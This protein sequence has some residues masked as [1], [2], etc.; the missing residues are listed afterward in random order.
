MVGFVDAEGEGAGGVE[1]GFD[2]ALAG[3]AGETTYQRDNQGREI[4]TAESTEVAPV[5]GSDVVLTIDRDLQWFA[6]DALASA[7]RTSRADSGTVV[8]M[9]PEGEILALATAPTFDPN[10][11]GSANA[12]DR[13]DRAVSDIYEPGSTSKVMTAAAVL[14]EK[15]LGPR[16][17]IVVPPC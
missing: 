13:G 12:D 14:E 9:T 10:D 7:V 3:V 17:A 15:A 4:S 2:R 5:A 1:L 16:S 11:P 6:Q 8:V